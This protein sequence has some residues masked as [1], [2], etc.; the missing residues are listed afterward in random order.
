MGLLSLGVSCAKTEWYG[1]FTPESSGIPV[2]VDA[3]LDTPVTKGRGMVNESSIRTQRFGV[4]AW[5]RQKE[6]YFDGVDDNHLY[7]DNTRASFVEMDG[8]TSVW[9]FSPSFWWPVG[10]TLSMFAYAPYMDCGGPT[11]V[12]PNGDPG[13]FPRGTYTV[14]AAVS[15]QSDF[16]LTPMV[17]D[18]TPSMGNVPFVFYHTLT[19]VHFSAN[20]YDSEYVIGESD[21]V[22]R[23]ESV[24]VS[25]LVGTNSFSVGKGT[26]GF[27]WDEVD[28]FDASVHDASYSVGLGG[29]LTSS[30]LDYTWDVDGLPSEDR[31]LLLNGSELATFYLLPQVITDSAYVTFELKAYRNS[32][33]SWVDAGFTVEP[34]SAR[35]TDGFD[36]MP[37]TTVS[38]VATINVR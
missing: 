24:T 34:F 2:G 7:A 27:K 35:L 37:G 1:T 33:G 30:Y 11:L 23:V 10:S 15:S 22:Y 17:Y 8:G 12:L 18:R 38:Y 9:M 16:C 21:W 13:P 6:G 28:Q 26:N 4:F 31:Y 3:L 25:G 29:G 14:P 5:W 32:G 36:W 20:V 19:R